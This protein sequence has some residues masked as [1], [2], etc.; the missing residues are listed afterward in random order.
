MLMHPQSRKAICFWMFLLAVLSLG[1]QC[2]IC[3]AQQQPTQQNP[4]PDAPADNDTENAGNK[5]VARIMR[6]FAGRGDLGDDSPP[7]T[8]LDTIAKLKVADDLRVELVASEPDVT[9][10]IHISFDSRGRMWVVQ[11]RQYPFPAGLKVV[12]YDQHLR[13]V[14]DRVPDAPPNHVRGADS[15]VVFEDTDG[16]GTYDSHFESITGLNIATSVAVGRGGTWVMNPPYLLFY[17]DADNDAIPDSDPQVHLSGFGLEDTHSVAN[18]L[19]LAPDGWLY[20]ANGST[21]TAAIQVPLGNQPTTSFQGQCVWRYHPEQHRFEI[22]AEGGGNPFGLEFDARG[23][24]FSGTN[25]GNTRGMYYPQGSYGIKNWGK[26]G[27]LTNP[28]AF[29]YFEHMGFEGDGRRFTEEFVIYDDVTLPSRYH[30]QMLAINPLQRIAF[31]SHLVPVGSTL[32]TTDFE[33]FITS[34]DRWFRPV[35]ATVGPDG[36]LYIADW[37]D[38]RLTHVDPRDNWHKS[39]GRIYRVSPNDADTPENRLPEDPFHDILP[40]KT[41]FDLSKLTIAQSIRLLEHPSRWF[42]FAA[43]EQLAQRGDAG[44]ASEL[45]NIV[46]SENDP[47]SLEA[48]WAASR[49]VGIK[50]IASDKPLL[51]RLLQHANADVRRWTIRLIGDQR[52]SVP[53]LQESFTRVAQQE[54]DPKTRSQLAS[55]SARLPSPLG[56]EIAVAM[57][58]ANS[59][60]D[61][62]D[63]HIPLLLWWSVERHFEDS[64]NPFVLGLAGGSSLWNSEIVKTTLLERFARR[65]AL[66][67]RDQALLWCADLL[68]AAP[69]SVCRSE[70]FRGLEDGLS[71][72]P[73]TP[74]PARLAD[75][76]DTL[77]KEMPQTDLK[78]RLRSGEPDAVKQAFVAIASNN[79]LTVDRIELINILGELQTEG[80]VPKLIARISDPSVT[81][82][83]AALNAV[84]RFP[85]TN[86]GTAI[87]SAYQSS[88]DDSTGLRPIAI[89]VLCSRLP[90]AQQ[91]ILEID[92]LRI[93]AELVTPDLV[94]QMQAFNNE[95]LNAAIERLWGSVRETPEAKQKQIALLKETLANIRGDVQS[96]KAVFKEH[97]GKCHTF[98]GEGGKVGPDLTG[99]ERTNFDF[100]SVAIIDPSAAIRD[101][102][103]QYQLLTVD[104]QIISGLLVNQTPNAVSIRTAED[105]VVNVNRSQVESLNAS[106][107]SIM[108]E[109]LLDKLSNK[110]QA[111]LLRYIAQ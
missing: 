84:S 9:Q 107:V 67:G 90:W 70:L 57:L 17:P 63:S 33:N 13:A 49:I 94:R 34:E 39:S 11:Y 97:C 36:L 85:D 78:L 35:D 53:H 76:V 82:R 31:A 16:D 81:I 75:V 15:I 6:Q 109:G 108:P 96:G 54:T 99:Y 87:A 20:G 110:K 79:N 74:L 83:R 69:D 19:I 21:T 2:P 37:Y 18:S 86:I 12:R 60:V 101:E 59:T 92:S 30:G 58:A 40:S 14:F 51:D 1:P 25:W 111:D 56:I 26:H 80:A 48:L 29:G 102:Y 7:T 41:K 10:P 22:Y 71:Q 44:V 27:P 52:L 88:M 103:A 38:T 8:P 61:N 5:E 3:P 47:R 100:L 73:G 28:F 24:V 43:I 68:A 4:S 65:C 104:G 98:F 23:Q 72:H 55:T 64:P 105:Q 50:N 46:Q 45:L 89:R 106:P 42:R 62:S 91:L 32:R 95:S 77:R 66:D 93:N